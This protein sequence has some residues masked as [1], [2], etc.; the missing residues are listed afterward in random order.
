MKQQLPPV[1]SRLLCPGFSVYALRGAFPLGRIFGGAGMCA[2]KGDGD[3][4]V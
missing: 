4:R 3:G 2:E 1:F